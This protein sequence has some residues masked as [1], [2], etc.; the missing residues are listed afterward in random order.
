MKR[1]S[2]FQD[3]TTLSFRGVKEPL[4]SATGTRNQVRLNAGVVNLLNWNTQ[5]I[6]EQGMRLVV[7]SLPGLESVAYITDDPNQG[8]KLGNPSGKGGSLTISHGGIWTKLGGQENDE[9]SD[10]TRTMDYKVEAL[11]SYDENTGEKETLASF[12]DSK[13]VVPSAH[14]YI[15]AV[16]S[17]DGEFKKGDEVFVLLH[18]FDPKQSTKPRRGTADDEDDDSAE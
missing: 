2:N 6:K 18:L 9:A 1:F 14:G 8:A 3:W 11:V 10:V 16:D 5:V 4:V 13:L 17:P 15:W 7:G 12:I